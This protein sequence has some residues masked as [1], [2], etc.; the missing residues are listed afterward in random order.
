MRFGSDISVVY[1]KY[2]GSLHWQLTMRYL[3]E[4]VH[5]VWTGHLAGGT[6]RRG[7]EEPVTLPYASLGLFPRDDWWT[8]WFNGQPRRWDIYCDITT[9]PQWPAADRVTMIDLDLDVVRSRDDGSA[10][11]V[12]EDEFATHSAL[13]RYPADVITQAD[14]AARRLRQAIEDRAE[15]FATAYRSWFARLESLDPAH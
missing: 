3:G 1:R 2:D 13:Y 9:V 11:V 5:G 8:G 7:E 6:M 15:P 12:D 4:D 10:Q 14:A